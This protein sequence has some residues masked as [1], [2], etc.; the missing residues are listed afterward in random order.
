MPGGSAWA[1]K[2]GTNSKVQATT[3]D[4]GLSARFV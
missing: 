3:N 2:V 1:A 4:G